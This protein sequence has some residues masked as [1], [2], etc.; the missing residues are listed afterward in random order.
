MFRLQNRV[1][2]DQFSTLAALVVP[3]PE[4]VVK[5]QPKHFLVVLAGNDKNCTLKSVGMFWSQ[6]QVI[7]APFSTF[8]APLVS[9]PE[10][11]SKF[12]RN[13]FQL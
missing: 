11:S 12:N 1:I 9:E 4:K 5:I 13:I 3:K 7:W 2:R 8:P 10:K 6:N